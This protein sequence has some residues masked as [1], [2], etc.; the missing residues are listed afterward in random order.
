[1]LSSS[2]LAEIEPV[3]SRLRVEAA[4]L[5]AV[6]HVESGLRTHAIVDGRPEP[7]IRFEGHYFDRRLSGEKRAEA[8]AA[9][10]ASPDAGA[11]ENPTTQVARWRLLARAET[12]DRRAA[13][14]STSWG[15]GQVMGA[16]WAWLGYADVD[17]LVAEARSGVT[18][19]LRLMARYI[20]KAGLAEALGS[21]DWV[22]FARGYNGPLFRRNGYD[23]KLARAYARYNTADALPSAVL[24]RGAR[25]NAVRE[26]QS[27]L[28]RH[29]LQ[30]AV[31]G[32]F[33]PATV[34]AVRAF[35]RRE[36]LI[37]D[38]VAGPAT[39]RALRIER[40]ASIGGW[41]GGLLRRLIATLA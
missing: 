9:G 2:V 40:P 38:R 27:A 35:Q 24:R 30:L 39:I 20:E 22:A 36:G 5:A 33:G 11:I 25:G 26:L 7:L 17:A 32:V 10:L 37:E 13:R 28:V 4:A 16:H 1:M 31:D 29:G 15:M 18:G 6:V 41:L 8:R 34:A 14:E 12:I 3:A 19:Q 21:R 23:R